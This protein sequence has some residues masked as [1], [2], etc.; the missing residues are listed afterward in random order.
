M[1]W[2]KGLKIAIGSARGLA[3]LHEDCMYKY[4]HI[5]AICYWRLLSDYRFAFSSFL[6]AILALSTG[7]SNQLIFFWILISKQRHADSLHI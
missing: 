6:Q 3:Y 4:I 1:D 2:P 5:I 7:T